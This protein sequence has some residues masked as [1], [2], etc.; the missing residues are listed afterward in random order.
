MTTTYHQY[1]DAVNELLEDK[2]GSS[3][4]DLIDSDWFDYYD[5]NLSPHDACVRALVDYNGLTE[6]E[7]KEMLR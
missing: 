1:I 4:D 3:V 6:S 2:V 5:E 7:A